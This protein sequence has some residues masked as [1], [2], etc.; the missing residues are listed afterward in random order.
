MSQKRLPLPRLDECLNQSRKSKYKG[1]TLIAEDV[2]TLEEHCKR[3]CAP[4]AYRPQACG[5]CGHGVL[6]VHD[7]LERRPLGMLLNSGNSSRSVHLRQR[8]VPGHLTSI[9][10]VFGATP[11]VGMGANREGDQGKSAGVRQRGGR[12]RGCATSGDGAAVV[13]APEIV[14][15]RRNRGRVIS[16]S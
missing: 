13:G 5:C 2:W 15:L 11:V 1:G 9:A 10:V 4:D 3:L 14:A 8:R 12:P 16:N 6:H 7:Y